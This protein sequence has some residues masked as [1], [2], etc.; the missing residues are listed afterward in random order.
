MTDQIDLKSIGQI[1]VTVV[2]IDESVAFY[3]DVM[4][5]KFLFQVPGQDMAFFDCGGVRLYLGA[6]EGREKA[7]SAT[8]YYRVDDI[9][10]T[11]KSLVGKG[12][13]VFSE[14]H[15]ITRMDDHELWMGFFNDPADNIVAIMSEAPLAS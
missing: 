10:E 6:P 15:V 1:H 3:R 8:I 14:P 9:Q 7:S 2:D 13:K 4:G 12:V 11:W 5:L